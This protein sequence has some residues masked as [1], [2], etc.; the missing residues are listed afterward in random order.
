MQ[1]LDNGKNPIPIPNG[2]WRMPESVFKCG[3]AEN[4]CEAKVLFKYHRFHEFQSEPLVEPPPSQMQCN[5]CECGQCQ[6]QWRTQSQRQCPVSHPMLKMN[7]FI[8]I[9]SHS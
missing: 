8:I 3:K 5:L 9:S 4:Y 2:E 7:Q 1:R 6:C